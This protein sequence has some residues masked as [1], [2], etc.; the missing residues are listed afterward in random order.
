MRDDFSCLQL[1]LLD[2]ANP[3]ANLHCLQ[4]LAEAFTKLK[5]TLVLGTLQKLFHLKK[6]WATLLLLCRLGS[7]RLL[8][9][10]VKPWGLS[11]TSSTEATGEGMT[12]SVADGRTHSHAGCSGCHLGHQTWLPGSRSRGANGR[13]WSRC[14]RL[15]CGRWPGCTSHLRCPAG[16]RGHAGC[17]AS[18][19]TRHLKCVAKRGLE[20]RDSEETQ[21]AS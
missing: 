21:A 13:W 9:S 17:A 18:A 19:S 4:H 5:V 8:V 15:S 16:R 2:E 14:G 6:P 12:Q 3:F 7:L 1:E 20:E 11:I 10:D